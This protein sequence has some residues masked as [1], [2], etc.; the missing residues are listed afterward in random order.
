VPDAESELVTEERKTLVRRVLAG[1]GPAKER[2]LLRMI[3]FE[4][5]DKE[6]VC[7]Q[8]NVNR[9]YLRVF[10]IAPRHAS[11]TF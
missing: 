2:E 1:F 7:R 3:F 5:R 6:E 10:S 4:E 8:L 11:D 9:E